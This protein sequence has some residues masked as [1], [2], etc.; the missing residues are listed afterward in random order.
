MNF[1]AISPKRVLSYWFVT[2]A[3]AYVASLFLYTIY[4]IAAN[5]FVF[6]LLQV[7]TP[8]LYLLF[9]WMYFRRAEENDLS[10]RIAIGIAWVALSLLGTAVLMGPVYGYPWT[11]AFNTA[12][13]YGQSINVAAVLVGGWVAKR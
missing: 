7:A 13:V 8:L 2:F 11:S 3:C 6:I 9:G 1:H 4:Q 5:P 12:I 10:S